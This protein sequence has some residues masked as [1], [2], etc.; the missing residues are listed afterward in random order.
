MALL[1]AIHEGQ[2][3]VTGTTQLEVLGELRFSIDGLK[4]YRYIKNVTAAL[5]QGEVVYQADLANFDLFNVHNDISVDSPLV[6]G[7]AIVSIAQNSYGWIQVSGYMAT[8]RDD[9][10]VSLKDPLIGHSTDGEADT[11]AAGEE[12][13]VFA[14]TLGDSTTFT[15]D[16][17]SSL[18]CSPAYLHNCLFKP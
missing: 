10:G 11:M 3:T 14:F 9:A 17:G 6:A 12:H 15:D 16:N 18:D 2:L 1:K 4:A 8:V 7:V 5:L 13:L